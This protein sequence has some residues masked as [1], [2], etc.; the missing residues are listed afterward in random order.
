MSGILN[1]RYWRRLLR[2][3]F[4]ESPGILEW[5]DAEGNVKPFS[6]RTVWDSIRQKHD[7]V[8]WY[9]VVW[10]ANGVPRFSFHMWLVV[11]GK[12]K[13]QDKLSQ[14]EVNGD[15]T[16]SCSLCENQPDSHEHIFFECM[17]SKQV[18]DIMKGLAGLS[19]VAGRYKEIVDYLIP[20]ANSKSCRITVAKLVFSATAYYLWQERNTRLFT[21]EKRSVMQVVD[22]IKSAVRLKLLSCSFKKTNESMEYM[23]LWNLPEANST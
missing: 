14:W 2:L 17:F 6:V 15:L 19:N 20:F 23:R 16:M 3:F 7:T 5:R 22:V 10:F 9:H 13:T 18:W 1:T 12:L 21:K 8:P 11:H 4:T